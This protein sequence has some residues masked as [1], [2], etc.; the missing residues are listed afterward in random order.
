MAKRQDFAALESE[1]ARSRADL[2]DSWAA[3]RARVPS[4]SSRR[5]R[6]PAVAPQAANKPPSLPFGARFAA[7]IGVGL[8][9]VRAL[10]RGRPSVH[11][12]R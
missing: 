1:I 4:R 9:F 6:V 10:K 12:S 3:L 2:A 5:R 11:M 8:M 7:M